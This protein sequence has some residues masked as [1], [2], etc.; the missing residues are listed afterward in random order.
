MTQG[1]LPFRSGPL[2]RRTDT[3]T[4]KESAATLEGS[5]E[6]LGELQRY[7]LEMVRVHPGLTAQELA[8]L[9]GGR[10][11]RKIGRRLNE[12]EEA[13]MVHSLGSKLDQTTNRKAMLWWPG[14][15]EAADDAE[16]ER[17]GERSE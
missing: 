1:K 14:S 6:A 3:W 5:E 2:A 17:A 8:D 10:D 11:S 15:K 13:G 9:D 16:A 7:A 4:S 12:L